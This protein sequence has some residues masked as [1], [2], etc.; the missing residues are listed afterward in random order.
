MQDYDNRKA[1]FISDPI[2][3]ALVLGLLMVG[4]ITITSTTLFVAERQYHDPFFFVIRH[5][6]HVLLALVM[7]F[8]ARSREPGSWQAARGV[9]LVIA[10]VSLLLVFVPGLGLEING[11]KRWIRLGFT[12]CQPSEIS[13]LCYL[14]YLA[15]YLSQETE[16]I[17]RS[18][19]IFWVRP[20]VWLLVC[21]TL[22][23]LQPDFGS[24]IVLTTVTLIT[25]F[26][27]GMPLRTF[28]VLGLLAVTLAGIC[29][30]VEPY[31]MLRI[32]SFT[33]P[34][35]YAYS[36]GYQ[37]TQSLM[38]IGRGGVWGVGLGS[39][40]QKIFYLPEA[41]TDFI[42]AVFCEELGMVGGACLLLAYLLLV[43]R[44]LSWAYHFEKKRMLFMANYTTALSS[45]IGIQTVISV[46][47]NLGVLPTKG[48][49]LPLLSYG[50]THIAV[51]FFA[52]GVLSKMLQSSHEGGSG[53]HI[54]AGMSGGD[55]MYERF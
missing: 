35:K 41:H 53:S 15:S 29:A 33:N 2:L 49:S 17:R 30:V 6:K 18:E 16:R 5:V 14:L 44:L 19:L 36:T 42:F 26:I 55:G 47:V 50:G 32:I 3:L 34:W 48:L 39:G 4:F 24:A 52:L 1:L 45:W 9:C 22:L 37:L 21:T 46:G 51:S 23:C 27:A 28:I 43:I 38:A 8:I 11:A 54:G 7:F 31:R 25:M 12:V 20:M 40:L 13:K 10:C